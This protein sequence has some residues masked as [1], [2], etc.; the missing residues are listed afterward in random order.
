MALTPQQKAQRKLGIGASS[1]AAAIGL[2]KYKTPYRLWREMVDLDQISDE[3][4]LHQEIGIALEPLTLRRTERKLNITIVDRQLQIFDRDNPWRW[5]TL[6]G[7]SANDG[8]VVEAKS[9]GIADPRDWGEEYEDNQVPMTYFIQA[10]QALAC[11]LDAPYCWMPVIVLNRDFRIYRIQRDLK[12]IALMT[13]Q[14]KAFM[15]MVHNKVA[16]EPEDMEDIKLMYPD[17]GGGKIEASPELAAKVLEFKES[18]AVVKAWGEKQE[19]GR[20]HV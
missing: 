13:V 8:A 16:P 5:V 2:S 18:K 15:D 19:I 1:A 11:V 17:S 6:D 3:Q 4:L 9:V 10:Q 14:Q 20:A 12:T 7:R